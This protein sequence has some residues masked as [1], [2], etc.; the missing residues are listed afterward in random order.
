MPTARED[1]VHARIDCWENS[2]ER[3]RTVAWTA[4]PVSPCGAASPICEQPCYV[5]LVR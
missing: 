4:G 1:E 3:K 5:D 2:A